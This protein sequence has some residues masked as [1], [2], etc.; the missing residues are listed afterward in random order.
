M[1]TIEI[2]ERNIRIEMPEHWDECSA[3][4]RDY[5][6]SEVSKTTS[7]NQ[8]LNEFVIKLFIYLTGLKL[9]TNYIVRNKKGYAQH[10]NEKITLL[11][12]KLC[13]WPFTLK[14]GSFEPNYNSVVNPY[15]DLRFQNQSIKGPADLLQDLTF[16]QFRTALADISELFKVQS[17]EILNQFIAT[18][19]PDDDKEKQQ[20]IIQQTPSYRKQSVLLWFTYCVNIIQSTA[21]EIQGS[22]IDFSVL[23]PKPTAPESEASKP[24]TLNNLGWTA[25]LFEVSESGVFGTTQETD[26]TNLYTILM[27][28]LKKYQDNQKLKQRQ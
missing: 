9:S 17:P 2:P 10:I 6:L 25:L 11:S 7:G 3:I 5:I 18:L 26:S 12:E 27:F 4:Q 8:T 20:K 14:D 28:L 19:Y 16:F 21:L 13:H 23:F 22:E 1:H 15:P 24:Q